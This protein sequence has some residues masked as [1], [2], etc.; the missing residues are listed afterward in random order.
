MELFWT[1]IGVT[2]FILVMGFIIMAINLSI[3]KGYNASYQRSVYVK[4]ARVA[5]WV[6]LLS[7]LWPAIILVAPVLLIKWAGSQY[8]E[9]FKMEVGK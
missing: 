4:N 3:S 6:S 1:W 2:L 8:R 9:V 7:P 5:M